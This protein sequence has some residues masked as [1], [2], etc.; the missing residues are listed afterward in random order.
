MPF[1]IYALGSP[2]QVVE[3]Y[4]FDVLID[5]IVAAKEHLPPEKPFHLFR[6]GHPFMLSFAVATG[7]DIFDSAAYALFARREKYL[8]NYGTANLRDLQYF[9]CACKICSKYT[10]KELSEMPSK[11]REHLLAWHN[12]NLCFAEIRRVKQAINNGRLWELLEIRAKN[13]PSLFRAF[14]Q[15][16]SLFS[17]LYFPDLPIAGPGREAAQAIWNFLRMSI[18]SNFSSYRIL[19]EVFAKCRKRV[20]FCRNGDILQE[21][22]L[23]LRVF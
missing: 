16:D 23:R 13:H 1:D 18:F 10:P 21:A 2:T 19:P 15:P 4:R 14:K 8:T 7:C 12:L 11:E 17:N 3:Q 22:G 5:M 9:P 20:I 6:A